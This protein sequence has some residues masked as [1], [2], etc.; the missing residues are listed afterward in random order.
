MMSETTIPLKKV[1]VLFNSGHKGKRTR[2][3]AI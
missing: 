1:N 3:D 2:Q